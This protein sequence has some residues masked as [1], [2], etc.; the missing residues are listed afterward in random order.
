MSSDS[1]SSKYYGSYEISMLIIVVDCY[2]TQN[3]HYFCY[4]TIF[5]SPIVLLK[6]EGELA[7][8]VD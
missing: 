5:Y 7:K 8:Y 3:N 4:S 6:D 2:L 1:T